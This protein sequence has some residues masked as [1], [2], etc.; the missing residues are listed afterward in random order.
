MTVSDLS[1]REIERLLQTADRPRT[2]TDDEVGRLERRLELSDRD[3]ARRSMAEALPLSTV[4]TVETQQERVRRSGWTRAWI[5]ACAA[6]IV[7][8]LIVSLA[9]LARPPAPTPVHAPNQT[10]SFAPSVWCVARVEPVINALQRWRGV[11]NWAWATDGIPDLGALV[12]TALLELTA[13]TDHRAA[14]RANTAAS[15]LRAQLDVAADSADLRDAAHR[16]LSAMNS[17]LDTLSTLGPP[18]DP[19]CPFDTLGS[20]RGSRG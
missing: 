16:R 17:A 20:A 7:A 8:I 10:P 2:L 14:D 5:G 11:E 15:E 1:E 9:T 18:A 6:T 19:A 4:A 12:E 3:Q 13:A